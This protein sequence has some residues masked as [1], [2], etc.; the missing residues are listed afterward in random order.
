MI[1][2]GVVSVKAQY[3]PTGPQS[4]VELFSPLQAV[5][6]PYAP[7]SPQIVS[8]GKTG[9][10]SFITTTS[11]DFYTI[12]NTSVGTQITNLTDPLDSRTVRKTTTGYAINDT[13]N[14]EKTTFVN[15]LINNVNNGSITTQEAV[16][17]L[18]IQNS[19]DENR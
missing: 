3:A 10:T 2:L 6:G 11:G 4:P 9:N 18:L 5:V 15:T 14:P 13:Y 7:L 12:N 17:L 1:L 16:Q 19:Y 8:F